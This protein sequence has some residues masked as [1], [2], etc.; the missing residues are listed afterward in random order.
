MDAQVLVTSQEEY[1][2]DVVGPPGDD[3]RW[4]ARKQTGYAL[5]DSVSI[6]TSSRHSA[7]RASSVAVGPL[8]KLVNKT[9]VTNG[10]VVR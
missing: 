10:A 4:Q 7:L 1:A 9:G 3:H 5:A 6:G 2:V 8:R